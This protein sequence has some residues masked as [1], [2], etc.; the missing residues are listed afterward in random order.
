MMRDMATPHATP[1]DSARPRWVP[2]AWA[3]LGRQ[4]SALVGEAGVQM[5]PMKG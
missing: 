3:P 5:G 1:V 2:I 4:S